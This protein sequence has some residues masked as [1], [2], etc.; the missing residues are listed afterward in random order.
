[1][2]EIFYTRYFF[3]NLRSSTP[4]C[5]ICGEVGKLPLQT[6]VDKQLIGYCFRVLNKDVHTFAYMVYIIALNVFHRYE[7]KSQWLKR[8]MYILDSCGLSYMWYHLHGIPTKQCKVIYIV[9]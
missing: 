1:M 2:L 9:K 4:N 3:L 5:M 6:L 8:V 7:Y